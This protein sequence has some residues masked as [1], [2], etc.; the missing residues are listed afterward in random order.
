MN[1][2]I[3]IKNDDAL[4]IITK[5]KDKEYVMC[6]IRFENTNLR[7]INELIR[8]NLFYKNDLFA[9]ST[10]LWELMQPQEKQ[11]DQESH[12]YHGLTPLDILD[13]LNNI[14]SPYC[15]FKTKQNRISIILSCLS[16]FGEPLMAVVEIGADLI[17]K[18]N[19]KINKL[20][21]MYPKS[22]IEKIIDKLEPNELLYLNK[23]P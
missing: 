14:I 3:N 7:M 10:T 13:A 19:A 1:T 2:V 6:D 11:D 16:H 17:K 21:T 9:N 15:I 18:K 5:F 12:N 22:N 20:V 23:L 4:D 8:S